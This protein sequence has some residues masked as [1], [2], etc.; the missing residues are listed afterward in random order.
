MT[1]HWGSQRSSKFDPRRGGRP[2]E[3][4]DRDSGRGRG[5]P[6]GRTYAVPYAKWDDSE[7]GTKFLILFGSPGRIRTSD[8]PVNSGFKRNSLQLGATLCTTY[9][10]VN[11]Q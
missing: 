4:R 3:A 11:A 2:G 1:W 6:V 8:Q 7:I 10:A 9:L 5:A